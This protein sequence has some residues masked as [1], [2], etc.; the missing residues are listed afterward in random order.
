MKLFAR[1]IGEGTPPVIVLHGL[2]GAS[3]NWLTLSRDWA[4]QRRVF[5]LDLRNHGRSPH[6]EDHT[7]TAMADDLYEFMTDHDLRQAILLGHSMGGKVAMT[8][9][10]TY[11]HKVERLIVVDISPAGSQTPEFVKIL[12]ILQALDISGLRSRQEAD[13]R[14]SAYIPGA[15]LRAF[16]LKN[17]VRNQNGGFSWRV[18][19][20]ALYRNR[21]LIAGEIAADDDAAY[22]GPTLFLR[23][24]KS[25]YIRDADIPI[26][27]KK[28]PRAR[29]I[30]VPNAGHWVHADQPEAVLQV[31]EKFISE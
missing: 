7:Y 8:F 3:D 21:R 31:V 28:F 25:P 19:L 9:S 2:L 16:L 12:E 29:I 22:D 17:L 27:R 6:S 5:L 1:E 15:G 13:E 10:L 30:T 20:E 24:E 26:I 14:L 4:K 23:G 11:P 18:N